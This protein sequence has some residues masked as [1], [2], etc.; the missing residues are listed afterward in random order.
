[1][2]AAAFIGACRQDG[3][4]R[5][6]PE[7]AGF[8]TMVPMTGSAS[9]SWLIRGFRSDD[10]PALWAVFHSAVHQVAARDYTPEQIRA[11][12]PDGVDPA[13]WAARMGAL[14]PFVAERAGEVVGYADLQ[15]DGR[16][17]HFFVAGPYGRQGVGGQLMQHVL[18]EAARRGLTELTAEVSRT[19]EPF[20][21]RYGFEGVERC[22][23]I[24]RGVVIP[25][26]RMR[27]VLVHACGEALPK[28][29]SCGVSGR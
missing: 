25:N 15:A 14:Q 20:F 2:T 23:P 17:D 16:I 7:D 1:M 5:H 12:A 3:Q 9:E 6:S 18:A 22:Q 27:K 8:R 11:W 4:E 28:S 19:A 21:A 13:D 24:R 10:A 26:V 29:G